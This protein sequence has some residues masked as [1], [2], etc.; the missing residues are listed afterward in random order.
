[1][2][3]KQ[4]HNKLKEPTGPVQPQDKLPQT[5]WQE[6]PGPQTDAKALAPRPVA[7]LP[8]Q[9]GDTRGFEEP[10]DQSD[11]VIPRAKLV[12]PT[13][14]E[15][16]DPKSTLRG[17][18]LI[19]SLTKEILQPT[20]VPLFYFKEYLRFNAR[21]PDQPGWDPAFA[22]GKLMWRTRDGNDQRVLEQC[23]FGPGGE[24]PIAMTTLNF[25]SLF[26]DSAMPLILSFGKTSYGAGKSL[27]SLAKFRGG[28]M[29]S[30]QYKLS[31][32][33]M[34]NDKGDFF[35]LKVDPA[36]D[37]D[38]ETFAAAESYFAQFGMKRETLKTH[39]EEEAEVV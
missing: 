38:A 7:G 17:G 11:L 3:I 13:S 15:A 24:I 28:A 31:I 19:N 2:A 12:Q 8:A 33:P 39:I 32:L 18:A 16:T 30:R 37:C 9:G 25:F 23:A 1:M 27:L 26:T 21:K 34:K 10:I 6:G 14:A 5:G 20:F 29:F 4:Q 36:G 22:P 35:V